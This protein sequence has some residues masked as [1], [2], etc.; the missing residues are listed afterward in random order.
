MHLTYEESGRYCDTTGSDHSFTQN[1]N[2]MRHFMLIALVCGILASCGKGNDGPG[3]SASSLLTYSLTGGP[4]GGDYMIEEDG[5]PNTIEA[6]AALF[7]ATDDNP[8]I[9]IITFS[10]QATSR[11]VSFQLPAM[12]TGSPIQITADDEFFA[13]TLQHHADNCI[14]TQGV[15]DTNTS[16]TVDV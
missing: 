9:A 2:T 3:G 16:L 15:P 1:S 10:N 11:S 5:D 4:C 13:M 6:T 7:P 8:E 14:L 12:T